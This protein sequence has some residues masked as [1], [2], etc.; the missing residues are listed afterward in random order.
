[1]WVA[2]LLVAINSPIKVTRSKDYSVHGSLSFAMKGFFYK[3]RYME[4]FW[5]G[6]F[7]KAEG[8]I[9]EWKRE[10]K[11]KEEE[12]ASKKPAPADVITQSMSF[13]P[14]TYWRSWP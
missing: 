2:I 8:I 9:E 3:D 11:E 6:F 5:H 4:D 10:A 12:L 14:D 1:M 13:T 7:K